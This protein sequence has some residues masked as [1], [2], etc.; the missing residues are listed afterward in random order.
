[1]SLKRGSGLLLVVALA[2]GVLVP[3]LGY[4]WDDWLVFADDHMGP[5]FEIA[6]RQFRPLLW[7]ARTATLGLLGTRPLGWHLLALLARGLL[8]LAFWW[9]ASGLWPERRLETAAASLLFAVYPG[10]SGQPLA[11][12]YSHILLQFAIHLASF[13]AMVHGLRRPRLALPM[14]LLA[15]AL[16]ALSL[17]LSE[18]FVGLELLRPA[19][20]WMA[21]ERSPARPAGTWRTVLRRWSPYVAPLAVYLIW[22]FALSQAPESYDPSLALGNALRHPIAALASRARIVLADLVSLGPMAWARVL[23]PDLLPEDDSQRAVVFSW[24]V[25]AAVAAVAAAVLRSRRPDPE[26]AGAGIAWGREAFGL[27]LAAGC[28]G[29]LPLWLAGRGIRLGTLFDRYGLPGAVGSSLAAAGLIFLLVRTRRQQAA[30]V[31]ILVGLAAGVHVRNA[32]QYRLDW[33]AQRAFFWQLSW[34]V[35]NLPCGALLLVPADGG[36]MSYSADHALSVPVNWIYPRNRGAC[37]VRVRTVRSA[38]SLAGLAGAGDSLAVAYRPPEC[39]R[40]LRPDEPDLAGLSPLARAASPYSNPAIVDL[41]QPAGVAVPAEV[42]G[43]EPPHDGC[44]YFQKGE[45]AR[46]RE[47][48]T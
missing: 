25:S 47:R 48:G 32:N 40:V 6:E 2:Y 5:G 29:Q 28:L 16:L 21:M 23:G 43:D 45:L 1:L 20:L 13:G 11:A 38:A 19:L 8:A 46:A 15:M 41:R 37:G 27:G 44:F 18:Y 26:G 30:C 39:L 10:F 24:I 22:R 3:W 14:T 36:G 35:P 4:Y 17:L 34:R 31:A 33:A 42:F 12:I 7:D 9:T